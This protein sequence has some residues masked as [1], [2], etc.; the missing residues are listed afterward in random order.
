MVGV[1]RDGLSLGGACDGYNLGP[2]GLG[3]L[4][5]VYPHAAARDLTGERPTRRE[6]TAVAL[7]LAAVGLMTY[8]SLSSALP[9]RVW[10]LGHST[11]STSPLSGGYCSSARP[12]LH[13]TICV[14]PCNCSCSA[15]FAGGPPCAEFLGKLPPEPG[16]YGLRKPCRYG[17]GDCPLLLGTSRGHM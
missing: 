1:F 3:Y 17:G 8:Q 6:L 10:C 7:V 13:C 9:S 16:A 14:R 2:V 5:G 12:Q 15:R 4:H 11:G